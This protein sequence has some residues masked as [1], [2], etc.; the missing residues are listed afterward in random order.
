MSFGQLGAIIIRGQ[1]SSGEGNL[2][3][4]T[5]G[6][7]ITAIFMICKIQ[8]FIDYTD[9]LKTNLPD[10]INK[11]ASVVHKCSHRW[12]GWANQNEGDK[13][14]ITWKLPELESPNESEKNESLQEQRT[15]M[16]DKSLITAI[17]IVSEIRRANQFNVYF[18]KQ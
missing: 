12:D 13:F 9:V 1:V 5:P 7:K 3:I 16:A 11:I 10:F 4:M 15:E 8:K 17:K 14:I 6:Q 2:E 18:R